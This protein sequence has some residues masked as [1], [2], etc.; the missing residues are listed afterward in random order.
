[1]VIG[2][3]V[4]EIGK[5]GYFSHF[6]DKMADSG[7]ILVYP[8]FL[9]RPSKSGKWFELCLLKSSRDFQLGLGLCNFQPF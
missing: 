5:S 4:L 2:P 1:M 6:G 9:L 8:C 3:A 7:Y